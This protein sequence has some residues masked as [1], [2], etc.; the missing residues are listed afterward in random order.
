MQ[1]PVYL[2]SLH[3]KWQRLDV[4]ATLTDFVVEF[5]EEPWSRGSALIAT[6]IVYLLC[7]CGT[8]KLLRNQALKEDQ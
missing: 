4:L 8:V 1:V 6:I 3:S 5:V 2:L 7:L